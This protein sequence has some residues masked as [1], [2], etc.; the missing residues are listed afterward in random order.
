MN[1]V[2]GNPLKGRGWIDI[3]N[4]EVVKR[5]NIPM[6]GDC[7]NSHIQIK[8]KCS[9][10]EYEKFRQKGYTRSKSNGISVGKFEEDYLMVTVACHRGKAGGKKFQVIEKRENVSLIVQKSLTIEA[11]RFW[12][13]TWASEGAY[14]VTPGGKKIAIEQ[15]KVIETE[16]VYLIYSEVMNAIKIGRAKN[17]EKRFTSLQTAHPY[18]LKIIKTLKVSGKKA[19]IDLE[20]QLHQQFADYRLSGEWFK[21]C[22]A[23]MNF[24]DDKNS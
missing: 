2:P 9:S 24:S 1:R 23:L 22:E 20:K 3:R 21:A 15:N 12:A 19:A 5:L 11:V 17:V 10:P 18:P 8:V 13:E 16:Y 7:T 14:L 4:L 6:T